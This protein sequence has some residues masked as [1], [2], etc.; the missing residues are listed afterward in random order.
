MLLLELEEEDRSRESTQRVCEG[1]DG[2]H[3]RSGE[4]GGGGGGGGSDV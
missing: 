4:G 2:V 1:D 3:S